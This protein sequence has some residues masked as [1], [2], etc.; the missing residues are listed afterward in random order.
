MLAQK[1]HCC[2]FIRILGIVILVIRINRYNIHKKK[3]KK[4][5]EEED[6]DLATQERGKEGGKKEKRQKV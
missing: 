6:K 4:A 2:I 3:K 1:P 5:G